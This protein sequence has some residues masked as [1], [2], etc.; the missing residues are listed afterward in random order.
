MSKTE[1]SE[2]G[3]N[4]KISGDGIDVERRIDSGTLA[5]V[6][7]VVMGT[8]RFGSPESL[9][10]TDAPGTHILQQTS[11]ALR[12]YLDEVEAI[13]K[14]DQIVAIGHYISLYEDQPHFSRDEIRSHF[15]TAREPLPKNFSRD[16]GLAVKSGMIAEAHKKPGFFYVT[17]TGISAVERHFAKTNKQK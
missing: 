17:K 15:S 10:T 2:D 16:F 4:L 6:M 13:H 7:A 14:A 11:V 5:A 9:R 1:H 8:H 12:E 3:F